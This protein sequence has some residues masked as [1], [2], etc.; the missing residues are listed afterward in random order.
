MNLRS[1]SYGSEDK[2]GLFSRKHVLQLP[3]VYV[4]YEFCEVKKHMLELGYDPDN[5]SFK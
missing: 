3:N 1:S 4:S 2:T 5:H